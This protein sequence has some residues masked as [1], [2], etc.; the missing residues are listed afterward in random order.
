[1]WEGDLNG[2]VGG[3]KPST[4]TLE[5]RP[6]LGGSHRR[7]VLLHA[8]RK[9]RLPHARQRNGPSPSK[10]TAH[11]QACRIE[12]RTSS[13]PHFG[14]VRA[15]AAA[16]RVAARRGSKDLCRAV[17]QFSHAMRSDGVDET[18]ICACFKYHT[19]LLSGNDRQPQRGIQEKVL[20]VPISLGYDPDLN[21]FSTYGETGGLR[22]SRLLRQYAARRLRPGRSSCVQ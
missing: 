16:L 20:I 4:N 22:P 18:P 19:P 10:M 17:V 1:M 6:E 15:K 12:G 7:R 3:P 5:H 8:N 14:H 11:S 2:P 13:P 21:R 9:K